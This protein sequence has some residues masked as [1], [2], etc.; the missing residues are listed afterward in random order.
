MEFSIVKGA[1]HSYR[2]ARLENL[3][4]EGAES[5]LQDG[6]RFLDRRLVMEIPAKSDSAHASVGNERSLS[7]SHDADF[8]DDMYSLA[9]SAFV[10]DRRFHLNPVFDQTEANGFIKDYIDRQ[11]S[12]GASVLKVRHGSELLAFGIVRAAGSGVMENV[13]A[14]SKSDLHGKM[15]VPTLYESLLNIHGGYKYRG[16]VSSSNQASLN[17]H[18]RLGGKIT[19]IFDEYVKQIFSDEE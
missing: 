17:L 13:L 1:S 18:F 6:F 10:T 5:L 2:I 12:E 11:K 8:S 9:Y 14:A 3:D 4:A 19:R 15:A 7:V 16:I